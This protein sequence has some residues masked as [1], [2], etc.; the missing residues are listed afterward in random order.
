M[1]KATD[2]DRAAELLFHKAIPYAEELVF[3]RD[4]HRELVAA[5]LYSSILELAHSIYVLLSNNHGNQAFALVRTML[6]ALI[7]LKNLV[8]D[9][10]YH[11]NILLEHNEYW[12][13]ILNEAKKG[14]QYLTSISQDSGVGERLRSHKNEMEILRGKGAQYL[15]V[16]KKFKKAKEVDLYNTG[17]KMACGYTHTNLRSMLARHVD[18]TV[19]GEIEFVAFK[20]HDPEDF[21]VVV[22]AF[23]NFTRESSRLTHG[24]FETGREHEF[25]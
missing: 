7:D 24:F 25:S 14:N 13:A 1:T 23:L 15:S 21:P 12:V 2:F 6:E 18:Q 17:Y 11:R 19:K 10:N 9:E 8:N 16:K 20:E 3:Q 5:L 22:E 4:N